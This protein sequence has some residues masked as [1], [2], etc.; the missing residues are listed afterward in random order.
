MSNST[1]TTVQSI[2]LPAGGKLLASATLKQQSADCSA[3]TNLQIQIAP[4]IASISCQ[5]QILR[6]LKPLIDIIGNPANPPTAA[7]QEFAKAAAALG[8]CLVAQTPAGVLPFLR[9]LLCL[10]IRSLTCLR[11]HLQLMAKL[12]ATQPSAVTASE[13]QSAVDSYQPIA[14]LLEL[15][16]GL[17]QIVG[18]SPPQAPPLAPGIDPAS[19]ASDEEIVTGFTASLQSMVDALGGCS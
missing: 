14:G 13:V 6:L 8:P 10:E 15:A 16:G 18:V 5:V 17:F 7:I 2:A 12:A 4:W 3:A 9:D 1:S 11:H 19:L